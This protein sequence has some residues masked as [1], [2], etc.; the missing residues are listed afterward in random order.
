MATVRIPLHSRKYPD[1]HAAIDEEDYELVSRYR[2]HP[3]TRPHINTFYAQANARVDGKWTVIKMHRLILGLDQPA[4]DHI[5]RNGLDNRRSNLRFALAG[6]NGA[7]SRNRNGC[8]SQFRGVDWFPRARK[9]RAS[10]S[11]KGKSQH[12]G[13]YADE[14]EAARAFDRAAIKQW[15]E[16]ATLNFPDLTAVTR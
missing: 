13:L 4:I 12:L 7:N 6:E 5:N 14:I 16:F 11:V 3:W 8:S 15:G 9:W 2:W 1:L 10:I